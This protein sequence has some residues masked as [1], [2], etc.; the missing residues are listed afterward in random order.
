MDVVNY[1]RL[2]HLLMQEWLHHHGQTNHDST[3]HA[4]LLRIT[5]NLL[6]TNPLTTTLGKAL[7]DA[8]LHRQ[9][10]LLLDHLFANRKLSHDI[11]KSLIDTWGPFEAAVRNML[12]LFDMTGDTQYSRLA[13]QYLQSSK[14]RLWTSFETFRNHPLEINSPVLEIMETTQGWILGYNQGGHII[15]HQVSKTKSINRLL[16]LL[17]Y[18][19]NRL[20]PWTQEKQDLHNDLNARRTLYRVFF[21]D[22]L[23]PEP[24][25]TLTI[26]P[27]GVFTQ[28]PLNGLITQWPLEGKPKFWIQNTSITFL[29]TQGMAIRS[30]EIGKSPIQ[31]FAP[32]SATVPSG[33]F[34]P[35]PLSS[36]DTESAPFRSIYLGALA[37]QINLKS[38]LADQGI[39]HLSTHAKAYPEPTLWLWEPENKSAVAIRADQVATWEINNE[40]VVLAT[41]QSGNGH[42]IR[43][44]GSSSWNQTMLQA[45]AYQTISHLGDME[46]AS[47]QS[48]LQQF[49]H[50]FTK[51]HSPANALKSAQENYL[52]N[53]TGYAAHPI[54]WEGWQAYKGYLPK[55]PLYPKW[56]LLALAIGGV[57]SLFVHQTKASWR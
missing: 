47:G 24:P 48:I 16:T 10:M 44:D 45:G 3:S 20:P 17:V 50:A 14:G 19:E 43:G 12:L 8:L 49:Y 32:F 15:W 52:L 22:L 9:N 53:A 51:G 39:T 4:Y 36:S 42:A 13:W 54:Y 28:L 31:H 35:L 30:V 2:Q 37:N 23:G 33:E 29:P 7:H 55:A 57:I 5:S 26:V 27:D 1:Y 18:D 21:E 41:C 40:L 6:R 34:S 46:E 11:K 56:L 25:K 38:A